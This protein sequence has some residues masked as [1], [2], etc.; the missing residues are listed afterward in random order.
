MQRE[1]GQGQTDGLASY[2]E[3]LRGAI[4]FV[5]SKG[6]GWRVYERQRQQLDGRWVT[7]LVFESGMAVRCIRSY[8]DDWRTLSPEALEYLSW[9]S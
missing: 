6:Q 9:R 1:G 4:Q 8:P 7:M 2:G 3:T 5:D